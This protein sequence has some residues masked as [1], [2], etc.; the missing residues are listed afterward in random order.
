MPL[1]T[2][3]SVRAISGGLDR[4]ARFCKAKSR[5]NNAEATEVLPLSPL[6]PNDGNGPE[7][8]CADPNVMRSSTGRCGQRTVHRT[9]YTWLREDREKPGDGRSPEDY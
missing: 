6:R 2:V 5:R 7:P 1:P 3:V 4:L 8:C 9:Q